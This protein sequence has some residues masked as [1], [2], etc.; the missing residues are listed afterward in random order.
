MISQRNSEVA[1]KRH[2]QFKKDLQKIR[3][4]DKQ[5][6]KLVKYLT[7]LLDGK[8]LPLEARDHSLQGEF[9]DVHEFHL[10]GDIIV[11]YRKIVHPDGGVSIH[12]L[13][14]GTHNQIFKR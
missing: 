10:G 2:K 11:L 4:T 14:I 3:I 13:R 9:K 12:L 7:T 5:F 1:L 6:E 8:D